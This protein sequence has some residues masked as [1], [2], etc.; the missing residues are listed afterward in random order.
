MEK[1][2]KVI[3]LSSDI[4]KIIKEGHMV[5]F[6]FPNIINEFLVH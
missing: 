1:V 5:E 6:P 2:L 4:P 3:K